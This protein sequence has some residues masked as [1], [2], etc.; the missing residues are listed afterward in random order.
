VLPPTSSAHAVTVGR[1][2]LL[3]ALAR[4]AAVIPFE[5]ERR[6]VRLIWSPN[7]PLLR[8]TLPGSPEIA[9][10]AIAADVLASGSI[11]LQIRYLRELIEAMKGERIRLA[12]DGSPGPLIALELGDP[13]VFALLMPVVGVAAEAA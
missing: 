11:V 3:A 1:T 2:E 7:E 5:R 10:D 12:V 8:L 6:I 9:D 4:V 13:D